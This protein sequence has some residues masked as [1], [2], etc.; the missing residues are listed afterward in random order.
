VWAPIANNVVVIVVFAGILCLSK[1]P[2]P[3]I[4]LLI[5]KCNYGLG[6]NARRCHSDA[7]FD[8]GCEAMLE[9]ICV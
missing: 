4:R 8:S 5:S 2:S 1:A 3:L 7:Y 6:H 9:S